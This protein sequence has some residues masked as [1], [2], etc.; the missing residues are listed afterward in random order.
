MNRKVFISE[1]QYLMISLDH[2]LQ[3]VW[4][5]L[6]NQN[7]L[8]SGYVRASIIILK[9]NDIIPQVSTDVSVDALAPVVV[10]HPEVPL[11]QNYFIV[12]VYQGKDI[13]SANKNVKP[14]SRVLVSL[15]G[16]M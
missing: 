1:R 8:F 10:L 14:S 2:C 4:L 11:E 12:K 7:G 6:A 5:A 9:G 15:G 13:Y 3:Q 16:I